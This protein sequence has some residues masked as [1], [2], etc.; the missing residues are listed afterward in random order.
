MKHS[1]I[2][3]R[4]RKQ[5]KRVHR[6]SALASRTLAM[7]DHAGY[8]FNHMWTGPSGTGKSTLARQIAEAMDLPFESMLQCT[9]AEEVIGY[10]NS[11]NGEWQMTPFLRVF[12]HGGILALEEFDAWF[13]QPL[14]TF[15]SPMANNYITNPL[16]GEQIKRHPDA[17]FIACTN[18][19]G[20]GAT[21]EFVGRNKLDAATL[22]RFQIKQH[23]DIDPV[24]ERSMVGNQEHVYYL[25]Q[26]MRSNAEAQGIKVMI[27]PRDTSTIAVLLDGGFD[28]DR[29]LSMTVF[30]GLSSNQQRMLLL[31][32]QE[33]LDDARDMYS[34]FLDV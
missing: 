2:M 15:N 24:V 22:N 34:P 7:R 32:C 5:N 14:V 4:L 18:T 1:T 11:I 20:Q 8:R 17:T 33:Y 31:D 9:R 26:Q 28:I 29:A 6:V 27:T 30:A 10:V 23:V 25:I 16:T 12:M 3:T 19:H 13:P 21:M